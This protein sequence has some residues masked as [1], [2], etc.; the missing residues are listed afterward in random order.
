MNQYDQY[1]E[2]LKSQG[3]IF[4]SDEAFGNGISYYYLNELSGVLV[5][6]F[7]TTDNE[8]LMIYVTE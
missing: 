2:Y 5:D 4:H 7:I 6:L 3:F 1:V 8:R